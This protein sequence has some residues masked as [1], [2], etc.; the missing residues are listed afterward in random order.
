[1]TLHSLI[2]LTGIPIKGLE[3]KIWGVCFSVELLQYVMHDMGK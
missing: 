3:I 1:M 2:E